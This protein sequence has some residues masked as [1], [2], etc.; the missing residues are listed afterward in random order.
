MQ[1]C[2]AYFWGIEPQKVAL[3]RQMDVLGA[4]G[5]ISPGMVGMNDFHN[6]EYEAIKAVQ[7]AWKDEGLTLRVIEGPPSLYTKTK[8]GLEG[9]DEEI[10][11]FI[12]FMKNI[13]GLGIDT[14]CYNWMPV[15]SWA[16]TTLDKPSR[17]GALVS[18][19][20][21]EDIADEP[22]FPEYGKVTHDK[23][24]KNMEYFLKV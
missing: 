24:W 9:R 18:S 3:A 19:F 16:R 22:M 15:I 21:T 2:L 7:Q 11:N 14:V 12:T 4:V 13:S 23:M 6:W 5:G 20:R 8:L 10:A 17:G 1:M